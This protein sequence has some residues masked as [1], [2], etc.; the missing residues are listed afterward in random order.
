MK[1][2]QKRLRK[3]IADQRIRYNTL[4]SLY[5]EGFGDEDNSEGAEF[6]RANLKESAELLSRL[7]K[8]QDEIEWFLE[9][10]EDLPF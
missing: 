10:K 2:I 3:A 9:G 8:L 7:H 1:N 6:V 4:A 5:L